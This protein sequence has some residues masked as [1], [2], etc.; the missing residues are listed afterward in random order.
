MF[1]LCPCIPWVIINWF[2]WWCCIWGCIPI[3]GFAPPA[4]WDPMEN[5]DPLCCI[6]CCGCWAPGPIIEQLRHF[7]PQTQSLYQIHAALHTHALAHVIHTALHAHTLITIAHSSLHAHTLVH[8][9]HSTLHTTTHL[10]YI[11]HA[12]WLHLLGVA[13][14]YV[15]VVPVHSLSHREWVLRN[16]SDVKT[17]PQQFGDFSL[18]ALRYSVFGVTSGLRVW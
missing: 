3:P 18:P 2:C 6:P 9:A 16:K 4:P 10:T 7:H 1:M 14:H 11:R 13:S 17:A 8:V 15:H 5:P 12:A